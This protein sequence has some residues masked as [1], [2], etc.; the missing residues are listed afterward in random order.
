MA[1]E[2]TVPLVEGV[3]RE[4]RNRFVGIVDVGGEPQVVHITN[5]GRMKELLVD[6]AA[7]LLRR[8]NGLT[9]KTQYTLYMVKKGDIW[10]ALDSTAANVLVYDD[11]QQYRLKRFSCYETVRREVT[12]GNSRFDISLQGPE[13]TM[14]IEIKC[15]TLV[16]EGVARFPDAPTERGR[17]HAEE[18]IAAVQAGLRGAIIFV[19]QRNDANLFR[20]NDAT[21]PD[22][23]IAL[24]AAQLAGV[25]VLAYKCRVTPHELRLVDEI[26]VDLS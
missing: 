20:P 7:V 26:P 17:K 8:A 25:Q 9:R 18:L 4:R 19:V 1:I 24:R 11:L 21:D 14:Y 3:F 13:K 5:T 23:G 15:C 6:G 16:T 22:F 10:V 2:M 12:Y